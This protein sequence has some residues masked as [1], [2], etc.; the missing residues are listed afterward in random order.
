MARPRNPVAKQLVSGSHPERLKGRTRPTRTRPIGEPYANMSEGEKAVWSELAGELPWLH[1][2]HRILLRLTCKLAAEMDAGDIAVNR[3]QVL[4][5]LLS[6]LGA[7]P[8]DESRIHHAEADEEDPADKF[9][10]PRH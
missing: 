6:K 1:S 10:G 8:T 4:S 2:A 9:F 7:T 5:A 3:S